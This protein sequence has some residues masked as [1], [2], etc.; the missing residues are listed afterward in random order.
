MPVRALP[1][2]RR[3]FR[4]ETCPVRDADVALVTTRDVTADPAAPARPDPGVLATLGIRGD[5]LATASQVHGRRILAL[6][7]PG[8]QGTGDSLVTD[9]AGL[10]LTLRVADCLPVFLIDP[11]R[12]VLGLVH[13]GWRGAAAGIV[14]RTVR[15]LHDLYGCPPA[16]LWAGIGPGIGPE[17]FEVGDDVH[18]AFGG[19]HHVRSGDRWRLDLPAAVTD[20]LVAAGLAP[21][22]VERSDEC[23]ATRLDVY[24]SYRAEGTSSRLFALLGRDVVD[25]TFS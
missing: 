4:F 10:V 22:A 18:A 16:D 15:A 11:R 5:R 21:G 14:S 23:T 24:H 3:V 8:S 17:R 2:G 1:D 19:R 13:A 6:S 20:E 7:T 9:R 25:A 12:G